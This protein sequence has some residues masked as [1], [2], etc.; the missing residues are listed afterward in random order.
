MRKILASATA[1]AMVLAIAAMP[2]GAAPKTPKKDCKQGAWQALL[3]ADGTS[4][5]NQ[6]DCTL[7]VNRG[8]TFFVEELPAS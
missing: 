6:G 5:R 7:H 3:R 2:A 4:F 1:G 8:G